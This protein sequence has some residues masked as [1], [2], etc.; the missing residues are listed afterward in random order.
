MFIG[1][2]IMLCMNPWQAIPFCPFL[3][4]ICMHHP[5]Y[6]FTTLAT[7]KWAAKHNKLY[8]V[9]GRTFINNYNSKCYL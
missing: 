9:K 4:W 6:P 5:H 8:V 3:P 2:V 1:V 7:T